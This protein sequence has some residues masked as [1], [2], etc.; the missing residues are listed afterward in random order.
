MLI[1][2]SNYQNNMSN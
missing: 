1:A 2:Q